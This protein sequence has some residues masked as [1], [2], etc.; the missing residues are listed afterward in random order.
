MMFLA[1]GD[2]FHEQIW[3]EWFRGAAGEY[4]LYRVLPEGCF[5]GDLLHLS[6]HHLLP[7]LPGLAVMNLGSRADNSSGNNIQRV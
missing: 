2:L 4:P 7:D 1:K 3:A 6:C 5:G